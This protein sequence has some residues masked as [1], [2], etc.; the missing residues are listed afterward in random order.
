MFPSP[1]QMYTCTGAQSDRAEQVKRFCIDGSG[2]DLFTKAGACSAACTQTCV[3]GPGGKPVCSA[4]SCKSP[5]GTTWGAPITIFLRNRME[6]GNFDAQGG[7]AFGNGVAP[8]TMPNGTLGMM[9]TDDEDWAQYNDVQ[10]GT[11]GSA[12]TFTAFISTANA[13]SSIEL[14]LDTL[15]GPTIASI[16]VASTGGLG[17]EKAQSA[18]IASAGISGIHTVFVR[19]NAAANRASGLNGG[20]KVIGNISYFEV[21]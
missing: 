7:S 19:F 8:Y 1:P 10:F 16:A 3:T 12:T 6:A 18:A 21:K 4:S 14:H 20:G 5:N 9:A 11:A 15:T 17:V 2:C 13:G